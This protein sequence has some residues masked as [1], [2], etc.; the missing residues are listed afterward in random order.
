VRSRDGAVQRAKVEEASQ[1]EQAKEA[2]LKHQEN[3]ARFQKLTPESSLWDWL[4][5]TT[6]GNE[7]RDSAFA[8]I[9]Q[10][11]R[12]QAD[13]E[14]MIGLGLDLPMM[15]LSHLDLQITPKFCG[16][17]RQFLRKDAESFRPKTSEPAP[18]Q[19]VAFRMERHL[20]TLRWLEAHDCDCDA[21]VTAYETTARLYPDSPERA[22][23]L[24]TLARLH[25]KP[26]AGAS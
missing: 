20:L 3:L 10:L 16:I 5:F 1:V 12:R 14:E 9:R 25:R 19:V 13:A 7:L 17:A 2:E 26:H 6:N 23:Y 21:A 15:E 8:G 11:P 4:Q 22:Q 18:Y 24:A